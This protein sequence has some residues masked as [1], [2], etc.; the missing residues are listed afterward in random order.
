MAVEKNH[1]DGEFARSPIERSENKVLM[2]PVGIQL[3]GDRSGVEEP[4]P[5]ERPSRG[6]LGQEQRKRAILPSEARTMRHP[7]TR[8]AREGKAF[9]VACES[10]SG[11]S[12]RMP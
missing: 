10:Q 4:R 1:H 2:A 12:L 9:S 7:T 3:T 8:M 5:E 11:Q 6:G